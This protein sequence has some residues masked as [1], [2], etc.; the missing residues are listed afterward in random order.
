MPCANNG[1][2]Q[3]GS[4]ERR[5]RRHTRKDLIDD[6]LWSLEERRNVILFKRLRFV[7]EGQGLG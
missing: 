6:I 1:I 3:E 2:L 5:R 7:R 4:E